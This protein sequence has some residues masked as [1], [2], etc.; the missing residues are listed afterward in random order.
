MKFTNEELDIIIPKLEKPISEDE[1]LDMLKFDNRGSDFGV[2][3]CCNPE[4]DRRID[5]FLKQRM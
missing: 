1:Y 5:A 2:V 3:M 4:E